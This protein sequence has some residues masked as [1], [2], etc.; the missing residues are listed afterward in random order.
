MSG[1]AHM[2]GITICTYLYTN[3]YDIAYMSDYAFIL[4]IN[5]YYFYVEH[6]SMKQSCN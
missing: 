5:I 6:G 1:H 2:V 3:L 4:K